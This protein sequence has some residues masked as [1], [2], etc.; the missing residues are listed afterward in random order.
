MKLDILKKR[1]QQ[2]DII[3]MD[4]AMGT[5]I[6]RR[7]IATTLPLWSAE[8]LLTNPSLVQ[9]IHEDYLT[10]GAEIMITNTFSTTRRNFEKKGIGEQARK[11]T[12]LACRLAKQA[13][14]HVASSHEV[15]LAG[16]VAPLE[17]CYSPELTPSD[18]ELAQEH[19]ELAQNL[20]DGGVDFLLLETMITL[21]ETLAAL[22]ASRKVG[23]PV[24]VSFCCNHS[25]RLLG[26]DSLET[27]IDAV[28]QFDPLFIGINCISLDIATSTVSHLKTITSFPISVYAQGNGLPDD[29]QGWK[30]VDEQKKK[31]YVLH[32]KQWITD[33]ATIIGG[34]CGTTPEDIKQVRTTICHI[35]SYLSP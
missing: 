21:R 4:G 7:G 20:K 3:L 31:N 23:L 22:R 11:A 28:E 33:G 15:Y 35:K 5:E 17:D 24:A 29:D 9:K 19:V 25:S 13:K 6:L 26:G 1:L 27:V 10:S 8:A 34:C 2:K 32:M 16:S 14:A 12:L 30:F 18:E